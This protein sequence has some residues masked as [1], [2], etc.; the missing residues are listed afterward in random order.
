MATTEHTP[1]PNQDDEVALLQAR[2]PRSQEKDQAI[3][4]QAGAGPPVEE[5]DSSLPNIHYGSGILTEQAAPPAAP[6][7]QEEPS[8]QARPETPA[9]V[10]PA[11]E[12]LPRDALPEAEPEQPLGEFGVEME[13][14]GRRLGG[15]L[16]P[17]PRDELEV[18]ERTTDP[19]GAAGFPDP[20]RRRHARR[21]PRE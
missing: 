19:A 7:D 11:P 20:Q 14:L 5:A 17:I 4:D 13:A 3:W 6:E 2:A 21:R 18:T 15:G 12:D 10:A 1:V 9:E 8:E 16:R